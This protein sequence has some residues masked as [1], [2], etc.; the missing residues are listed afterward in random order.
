MSGLI[1]IQTASHSDGV[2]ENFIKSFSYQ[3]GEERHV[4]KI[5]PDKPVI[6]GAVLL[7]TTSAQLE[8]SLFEIQFLES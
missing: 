1:W 4:H 6:W 8:D 5:V 3:F 7:G 2:P